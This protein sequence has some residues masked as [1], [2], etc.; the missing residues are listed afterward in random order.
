M[1]AGTGCASRKRDLSLNLPQVLPGRLPQWRGFNLLEKFS[2]EG[3]GPF[4][5]SD[6]ETVAEWGFNFVR[7]PMSYRCWTEP[8]PAR[9]F[10]LRESVLREIDKAVD[11]GRSYGV[12]VNLNFHRAPGYC[13][14]PPAEP[15]DLWRDTRA[16][17]AACHHWRV[18]ARRYRGIPG[19]RL[20]FDLLNEPAKID[21]ETYVR[22]VRQ[23]VE[24]IRAEDPDRLIV[25]DGLD[26]GN[27]PVPGLA[28]LGVGQST[29]GYRP[30]SVSHYKASWVANSD[31]FE[32]NWPSVDGDER[33]D[34]DR[35]RREQIEPWL[36]LQ[37]RGVGVHVGEWGAFRH[38]P[39]RV[40]LAWMKDQLALWNEVGWGWALWNL[41][42]SFGVLDSE[43]AD[44]QYESYRGHQLDRT[45]LELLRTGGSAG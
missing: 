19:R 40:V 29:R 10:D 26:W 39:H 21:E 25:A 24:A 34:R 35:L 18:F 16:L 22:V 4:H 11:H 1:A 38:T 7:L 42:G 30:M 12:H 5:E 9:W 44:V 45:M 2:D 14:N 13:V 8:D 37:A 31:R 23:M 32:P 28:D 36:D 6:F 20:S 33:W 15:L 43:R 17:E 3:S 41:R 27:T